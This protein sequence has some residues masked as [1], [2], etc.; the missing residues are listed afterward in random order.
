MQKDLVEWLYILCKRHNLLVA[1]NADGWGS[2]Y[3][4]SFCDGQIHET[5]V[6]INFFCKK[7]G[8]KIP[9]LKTLN[10]DCGDAVPVPETYMKELYELMRKNEKQGCN[11]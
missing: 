9:T 11:K 6:C 4:Q 1:A 8:F 3:D 5:E 10:E 7:S 2:D